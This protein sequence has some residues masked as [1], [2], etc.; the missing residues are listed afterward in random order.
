M[1]RKPNHTAPV[2]SQRTL[3]PGHAAKLA[4]LALGLTT[5]ACQK[6]P[7]P[8]GSA[9]TAANPAANT[10]AASA[11]SPAAAVTA[12]APELAAKP[13]S[14]P[15]PGTPVEIGGISK[16]GKYSARLR[17]TV[18][19]V[20]ELFAVDAMVS[21]ADGMALPADATVAMDATMPE[22]RH[23][24]MTDP[25]TTPLLAGKWRTEGMR[26]H[27][28]GNWM[29]HVKVTTPQGADEVELPF[30]QPPEAVPGL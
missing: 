17:F 28:Q 5:L 14:A 22:H 12:V 15:L 24:M 19:Q 3:T 29:F 23:G 11:V 27:M 21:L 26:L 18:P 2:P 1:S 4:A 9:A 30:V 8:E 7:P 13:R 25:V 16:S 20:G 6:S 10:A